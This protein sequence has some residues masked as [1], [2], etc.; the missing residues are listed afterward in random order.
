MSAWNPQGPPQPPHYPQGQPVPPQPYPYNVPP[1]QGGYPPPPYPYPPGFPQPVPLRVGVFRRMWRAAGPIAIARKV[2]RPSRPDRVED[3]VVA[4]IQKIRTYVGLG[5][6]L[7]VTYSY[8]LVDSA[9]DA[10]SER[11]NDSWISILVLSVTFPVVI[12]VLVALARPPARQQLLRRA[13]KPFGAVLAII[14][15]V[16]VFPAAILTGLADGKLAVNPVMSVITWLIT[17]SILVWVLPFIIYGMGLS[18]LHVFRTVDIHETVPPL[19]TMT[20]VWEMALVN[21]FTGSYADVPAGVRI[22]FLLGGPLSVTA[23]GLW[24]LRRLRANYGLTVRGS[25]MR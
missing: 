12:G 6:V 24:E 2:F 19:L 9:G 13:A 21:L 23:V 5:A 4:R 17:V 16:A 14:G 10:A 22:V 25:L 18:L 15:G 8:K 3:E 11:L 1:H 7:W 20:L